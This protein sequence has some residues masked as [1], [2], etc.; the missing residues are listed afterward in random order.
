MTTKIIGALAA[1]AWIASVWDQLHT[2]DHV[3]ERLSDRNT[4][5]GERLHFPTV[6]PKE[7][8]ATAASLSY[9]TDI[10]PETFGLGAHVIVTVP[11][12]GKNYRISCLSAADENMT[13]LGEYLFS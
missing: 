13:I 4:Y 5:P 2:L 3:M 1:K 11:P 6:F 9:F 10:A 8:Y 7:R 12:G